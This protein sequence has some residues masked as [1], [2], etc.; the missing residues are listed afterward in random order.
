MLVPTL[1]ARAERS[2]RTGPQLRDGLPPRSS[3]GRC[4][5]S[6]T[7][8]SLAPC[9]TLTA[10]RNRWHVAQHNNRAGA[11]RRAAWPKR[12]QWLDRIAGEN[13]L[14]TGAKAWLMLLTK[15]SGDIGKPVWGNQVKMAT[16]S[17]RCDRSVRR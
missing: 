1:W 9:C 16:E 10:A 6:G 14:T 17:E 3:A 4:C 15:R 5:S 8:P 13:R 2:Q 7:G 12:R 11:Q